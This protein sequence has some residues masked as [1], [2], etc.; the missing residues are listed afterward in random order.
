MFRPSQHWIFAAVGIVALA[1][2][3]GVAPRLSSAEHHPKKGKTGHLIVETNPEAF[4]PI[5]DRIHLTTAE[6]P[7]FPMD[8]RLL[9][10]PSTWPATMTIG[11]HEVVRKIFAW[12]G[13]LGAELTT[14]KGRQSGTRLVLSYRKADSDDED[15]V[16]VGP[17]YS[18][19]AHGQLSER[20]YYE[21]N[22]KRLV[23]HDYTYYK[24]GKLL[25]YSWR[26]EPRHQG[27][28]PKAYE[29]FSEFFDEDGRLLALG[30]EKMNAHSR[31]SLYAW[32]GAEVPYDAFRMKTHVLYSKAHPGDR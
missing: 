9:A 25:G 28:A 12:D 30:Y 5:R 20:I 22:R 10:S 13:A 14:L 15:D 4:G 1:L 6:V 17:R 21:P 7:A 31:D 16:T 26:T 3:L 19:N 24:S 11:G 8:D 27:L 2:A 18:W 23:T 29:F 32:K